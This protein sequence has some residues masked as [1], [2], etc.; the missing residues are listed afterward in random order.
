MNSQNKNRKNLLL[1][2]L[3]LTLTLCSKLTDI[4]AQEKRIDSLKTDF[5]IFIKLLK[6][7]LSIPLPLQRPAKM[8]AILDSTC[9]SI[10]SNTTDLEFYRLLKKILST[11]PET[12]LHR[13]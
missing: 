13:R 4:N 9:N 8:D 3:C 11:P 10:Q 7:Q 6:K 12:L 5:T 1:L 2:T